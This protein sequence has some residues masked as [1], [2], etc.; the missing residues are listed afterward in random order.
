MK[1]RI[2]NYLITIF[3]LLLF[4]LPIGYFLILPNYNSTIGFLKRINVKRGTY[5]IY[6]SLL[7]DISP[8]KEQVLGTGEVLVEDASIEE[9]LGQV[10]DIDPILEKI[11]TKLYIDSIDVEGGVFQGRDSHTM[12]KGFWHFPTSVYPGQQGNSVIIAHRYLHLPP[13]KDTF[14]NLDKVKKGD[15]IVV[16]Q[17]GNKYTY[18]VSEVKIVEK[19]DISVLQDTSEHQMTLITCTPLWTSHQRLAVIAKLDKLYQKT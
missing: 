9:Y 11:N 13:A 14:F 15:N 18:I 2:T 17:E 1:K 12:D 5:D 3:L 7:T 16:K 8:T 19:N 4:F 10:D 6:F